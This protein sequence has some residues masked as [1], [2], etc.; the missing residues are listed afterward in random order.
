MK[1]VAITRPRKFLPAAEALLRSK[2]LEPVPVP[3]MELVPRD[4]GELEAFFDRLKAGAVDVVIVTSQNAVG[5]I[6][7][8][9]ADAAALRER[10]NAVE[11]ISIGPKTSQALQERGIKANSVPS[12]Y[13]SDGLVQDFP[14]AGKRV[15]VLRSDHG[16]PTLILGLDSGGAAVREVIVYDIVPLSGEEQVAFVRAAL[17]GGIDAFTFTSTM[18]ARSLLMMGESMR[19]LDELKRAINDKKVA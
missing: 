19:A 18:T 11:V 8:R 1:R 7:D 12:T 16:N 17:S 3:M 6:F 14:L 4:D 13:S 10:L 2:G 5:F 15:E 9:A